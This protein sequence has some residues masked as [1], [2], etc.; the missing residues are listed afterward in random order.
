MIIKAWAFF[1]QYSKVTYFIW[2][3]K[4]TSFLVIVFVNKL[5]KLSLLRHKLEIKFQNI[6]CFL[7]TL[8][9][10]YLNNQIRDSSWR[11]KLLYWYNLNNCNELISFMINVGYKDG[12][13]EEKNIT[14][15]SQLCIVFCNECSFPNP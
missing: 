9:F 3:T 2:Y 5:I 13:I 15:V 8:I 1:Y 7:P 11:S 12:D 4:R 14:L 6:S 10:F